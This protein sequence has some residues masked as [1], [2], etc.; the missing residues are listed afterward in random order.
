M[1]SNILKYDS[2]IVWSLPGFFQSETITGVLK[3]IIRLIEPET[4]LN[5]AAYGSPDCAWSSE[6]IVNAKQK[7]D[8]TTFE[9]IYEYLNEAD[10]EALC[11]FTS[12][13]IEKDDLNDEYANYILTKALENKS[14]FIVY[15]DNLKNYIK[16]KDSNAFIIA[17]YIKAIE[18][19][20]GK[21]N[22]Q[23][24]TKYYNELLKDYD[25]VSLRPEY[26]KNALLKDLS[27]IDDLS[28]VEVIINYNCLPECKECLS[29]F[30]QYE[31][32]I[33]GERP[34]EVN[35][36]LKF[37]FTKE[38]YNNCLAL[39]E[40]EVNLL[41]DKG[42]RQFKYTTNKR[43][44]IN[45]EIRLLKIMCQIFKTDGNNYAIFD[46]IMPDYLGRE[47][48]YFQEKTRASAFYREVL[49]R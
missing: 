44:Q 22:W 17:S 34:R 9:L 19:F 45:I 26:V 8:D 36:P 15:D 4:K 25:M 37:L 5:I 29:H 39:S 24:E 1:P 3:Q 13:S 35:C 32:I 20:H 41:Y 10:A 7:A 42:V 46:S 28:K 14:K 48:E 11:N 6:N 27:L 40:K 2:D 23:E 21:K 18:K 38:Q 30:K 43:R 31:D 16:E 47:F 49:S 33:K 12:T